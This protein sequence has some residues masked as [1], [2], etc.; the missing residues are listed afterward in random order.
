MRSDIA[1]KMIL[2]V[3]WL[4]FVPA[5]ISLLALL[6]SRWRGISVDLHYDLVGLLLF[7]GVL[8]SRLVRGKKNEFDCFA[9]SMALATVV[10]MARGLV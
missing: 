1:S 3:S 2:I 8:W 4:I 7:F 10:Q 9:A 5:W 6:V